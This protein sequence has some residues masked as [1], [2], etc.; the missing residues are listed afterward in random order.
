MRI[1]QLIRFA[2]FPAL[3]AGA[4]IVV[5]SSGGPPAQRTGAP[6]IAAKPAESSCQNCHSSNPINGGATISFV[7]APTYYSAGQTYNF[8]VQIASSQTVGSSGRMWS[9][10]LTAVNQADGNGVGTFTNVL[11]E[12]TQIKNGSGNF[13]TRRYIQSFSDKPGGNTPVKWAVQWTAPTPNVGSVG[14]YAAGVAANGT[15]GT[16]GD[17]VSTA[18]LVLEDV[19]PTASTTWGRVKALYR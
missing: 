1:R 18:S 6:A 17:W 14:F 16:S 11:G 12:E 3:V 15:G 4:G 10:E 2:I 7:N 8:E 5:A 19:T 9:F 13:S